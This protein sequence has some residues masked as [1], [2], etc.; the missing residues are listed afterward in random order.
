MRTLS[1]TVNSDLGDAEYLPCESWG[2]YHK[3]P[4]KQSTVWH[5]FSK[6]QLSP[7]TQLCDCVGRSPD[8]KM[9]TMGWECDSSTSKSALLYCSPTSKP[10]RLSFKSLGSSVDR[11]TMSNSFYIY[12]F[13]GWGG[14]MSV[15][16]HRAHSSRL[17]EYSAMI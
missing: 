6:T 4:G 9:F 15:C 12:I 5:A 11:I 3:P 10:C 8:C 2:C 14:W 1:Q 7:G 17:Q 16:T 13:W